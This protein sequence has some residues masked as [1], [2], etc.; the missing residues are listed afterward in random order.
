MIFAAMAGGLGWGI[1]GQYGHET[2]AMIA[3][4]LVCL[5]LA[6]LLCPGN[7]SI[8]LL[9]AVA[10]GTIGM[11]IGGSM[12]YGATLG[13]TQN[14][15]VV[16]NWASLRWGLLG[17]AVKGSIWIGF[18]GLFFGIGLGGKRYTPLEM[19]LLLLAMLGASVLGIWLL[20]MPFNPEA[21]HFPAISFSNLWPWAPESSTKP[22]FE[23]WGGLGTALLVGFL[24]CATR[25]KDILARNLGLWGLLGGALG[26]PLGQCLQA[27]HAWNPDVFKQGIWTQLD[28]H[29]NWWNNMETTFGFIMGAALGLGLW[30]NRHRINLT[31]E[32]DEKI[33]PYSLEWGLMALHV[34]LIAWMSLFAGWAQVVYDFGIILALVPFVCSVRGRL[35][36]WFMVMLITVLPIAC[37]TLYELVWRDKTIA[38]IPG[39]IFYFILPLAIA[40]A[41]SAWAARKLY[42]GSTPEKF[43]PYALLASIWIY[44]GLNFATFRFAWPWA[45]W[46]NRTPN[47][48]VFFIFAGALTAMVFI[49]RA[50]PNSEERTASET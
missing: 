6:F 20:N 17:C 24:Y 46:T 33:L 25:K 4:T 36:P 35:W 42:A 28:P 29:M 43:V 21:G 44:I 45:D 30:L 7:N 12:T 23:Y 26:F 32:A 13:L 48:I 40:T 38:L 31:P 49:Y 34:F 19:L 39:W 9:R 18:A 11:G 16:G 50:R 14:A 3:G 22:R 15:E 41:L 8:Q 27:Y 2:G 47:G 37:Q 10:L 1:R 5:T